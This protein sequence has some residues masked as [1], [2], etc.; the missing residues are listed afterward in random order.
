M[1]FIMYGSMNSVEFILLVFIALKVQLLTNQVFF[2]ESFSDHR[3]NIQKQFY[4]GLHSDFSIT[5][6]NYRILI[7]TM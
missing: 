2:H 5:K 6:E 4:S 1:D 3:S 7:C